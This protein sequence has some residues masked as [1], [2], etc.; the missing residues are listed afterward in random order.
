MST[1]SLVAGTAPPLQFVATFQL[2]PPAVSHD[3]VAADAGDP[4][5]ISHASNATQMIYRPA[6]LLPNALP[7]LVSLVSEVGTSIRVSHPPPAASTIAELNHTSYR[8]VKLFGL[9]EV[10]WKFSPWAAGREVA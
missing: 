1:S 2:P 4:D 5:R 10:C 6:V 7:M 9:G 3:T 8:A